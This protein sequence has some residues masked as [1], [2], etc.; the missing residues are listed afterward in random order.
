MGVV[1]VVHVYLGLGWVIEVLTWM[2]SRF[3]ER[4]AL[5]C[6]EEQQ[7]A[8]HTTITAES[9]VTA[10]D[11]ARSL[12]AGWLQSLLARVPTKRAAEQEDSAATDTGAAKR[13]HMV[14]EQQGQL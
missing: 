11:A 8:S 3:Y 4:I 10:G 2:V 9:S 12:A 5:L 13:T 1:V 14:H 7:T 6:N